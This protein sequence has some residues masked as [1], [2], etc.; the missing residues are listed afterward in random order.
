MGGK[1]AQA[2]GFTTVGVL[3]ECVYARKILLPHT[4]SGHMWGRVLQSGINAEQLV[5]TGTSWRVETPLCLALLVK[6]LIAFWAVMSLFSNWNLFVSTAVNV[7][8]GW[9]QMSFSFTLRCTKKIEQSPADDLTSC[10]CFCIRF[11]C[12]LQNFLPDIPYKWNVA[13]WPYSTFTKCIPLKK[14]WSERF[15][16]V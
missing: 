3:L 4:T 10:V 8:P 5:Q 2:E 6:R 14:S 7:Q 16:H 12:D 9:G 1:K 13:L 15:M 11:S